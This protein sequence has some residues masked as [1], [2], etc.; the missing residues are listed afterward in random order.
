MEK[1]VEKISDQCFYIRFRC[2]NVSKVFRAHF[3]NIAFG[4]APLLWYSSNN[5]ELL[6][7]LNQIESDTP[8]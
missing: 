2:H 8:E 3:L 7:P 4:N 6:V 1:M 5:V